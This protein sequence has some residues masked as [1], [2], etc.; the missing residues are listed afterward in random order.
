MQVYLAIAEASQK[1]GHSCDGC[2]WYRLSRII[3]NAVS[4]CN[5]SMIP[6]CALIL[7]DLAFGLNAARN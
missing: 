7:Q 4:I 1:A 6:I 3:H 2:K 5:Y